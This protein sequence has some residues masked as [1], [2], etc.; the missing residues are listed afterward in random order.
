M[1]QGTE[2]SSEASSGPMFVD[3][4]LMPINKSDIAPTTGTDGGLT[5]TTMSST[6]RDIV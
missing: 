6:A 5:A 1:R 2:A 3:R 4:S